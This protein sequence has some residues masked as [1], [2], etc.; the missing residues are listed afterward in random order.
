MIN[1]SQA[2]LQAIVYNSGCCQVKMVQL[3]IKEKILNKNCSNIFEKILYLQK[4]IDIIACYDITKTNNS[5]NENELNIIIN[6]I[7]CITTK[8]CC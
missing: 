3:Y 5:I 8:Y 1:L 6:N 2:N 7:K 4:I